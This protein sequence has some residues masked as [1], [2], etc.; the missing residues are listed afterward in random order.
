VMPWRKLFDE[1]S[2]R[3]YYDNDGKT[4][5]EKPAD[6]FEWKRL[7]DTGSGAYFYENSAA[8]TQWEEPAEWIDISTGEEKRD[9]QWIRRWAVEQNRPF[10]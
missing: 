5:W 6:F 7:L 9:I 1:G 8:E 10:F 3:H 4:Q 2:Q